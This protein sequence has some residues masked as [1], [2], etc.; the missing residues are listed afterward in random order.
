MRLVVKTS[1]F[2]ARGGRGD[3]EQKE[4]AIAALSVKKNK[5]KRKII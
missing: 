4:K 2:A 1:S 3:L 5:K